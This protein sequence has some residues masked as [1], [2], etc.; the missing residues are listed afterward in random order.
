MLR[1]PDALAGEL[2]AS[3]TTSAPTFGPTNAPTLG[4]TSTAPTAA[5]TFVPI[6]AHTICL[7]TNCRV[8]LFLAAGLTLF[9]VLGGCAFLI[10]LYINGKKANPRRWPC[11][12][13]RNVDPR[14]RVLLQGGSLSWDTLGD[15]PQYFDTMPG[16]EPRHDA[17][18]AARDRISDRR[19]NR[20][21][22]EA[23]ARRMDTA[24]TGGPSRGGGGLCVVTHGSGAGANTSAFRS[25][26]STLSG[27][28]PPVSPRG[29]LPPRQ[30]LSPTPEQIVEDMMVDPFSDDGVLQHIDSF[31]P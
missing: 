8:V 14:A 30:T 5:P 10:A 21:A 31:S 19:S 16:G 18:T 29:S 15:N 28:R 11:T 24:S 13:Q 26:R 23:T 7:S 27:L 9:V 4:N 3:N 22:Q 2:T 1:G 6:H 25:Q 17:V 20:L 12:R